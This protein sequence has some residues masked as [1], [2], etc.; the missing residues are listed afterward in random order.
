MNEVSRITPPLHVD[1]RLGSTCLRT[2]PETPFDTIKSGI[3]SHWPCRPPG[4]SKSTTRS[5]S[6]ATHIFWTIGERRSLG[7]CLRLAR[8]AERAAR[9]PAL[10]SG[11]IHLDWNLNPSRT[12]QR[13]W[14]SSSSSEPSEM[15]AMRSTASGLPDHLKGL[16]CMKR[17]RNR[18]TNRFDNVPLQGNSRTLTT[19][20]PA[21]SMVFLPD[22]WTF[23]DYFGGP[24]IEDCL[25]DTV[26]NFPLS[27]YGLPCAWSC[28]DDFKDYGY[29]IQP[30][31]AL[32]FNIQAPI[33]VNEHVL[34]IAP[35][36]AHSNDHILGGYSLDRNPRHDKGKSPGK[37]VVQR[38]D[39]D[40]N[41]RP[42]GRGWA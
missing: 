17:A 41:S 26:L 12:T 1:M 25:E 35:K 16:E 24:T 4:R 3:D 37:I 28:W 19:P 15:P 42:D 20:V 33:L 30:S 38:C 13:P 31:F 5:Q 39:H 14:L 7:I 8:H 40:G 27:L 21:Q 11:K 36:L 10:R 22:D 6:C 9:T 23:D 2:C 34:P 18:A 32:A 29:R